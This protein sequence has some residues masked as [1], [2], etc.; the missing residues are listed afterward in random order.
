[1]RGRDGG[2][3]PHSLRCLLRRDRRARANCTQGPVG[4]PPGSASG[5]PMAQP[6]WRNHGAW[7]GGGGLVAE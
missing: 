2:P 1:M 5:N 3:L 7:A 6:S 4:D